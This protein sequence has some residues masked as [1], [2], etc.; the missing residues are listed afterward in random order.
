DWMAAEFE[1]TFLPTVLV[2]A[3]AFILPIAEALVG[4][5]L[6]LGVKT[7]WGLVGGTAIIAF[8]VLGSCLIHKWDWVGLQMVFAIC[9]YLLM[10]RIEQNTFSLDYKVVH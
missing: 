4:I 7:K 5:S 10:E 6:I 1:P 9:F 2:R 3:F 8:L